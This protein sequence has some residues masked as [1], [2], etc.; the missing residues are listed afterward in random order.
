M[1]TPRIVTA[2]MSKGADLCQSFTLFGMFN[3]RSLEKDEAPVWARA[4]E[5]DVT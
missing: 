1:I 3:A 4:I 2:V 5:G